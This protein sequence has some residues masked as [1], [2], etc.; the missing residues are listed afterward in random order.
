VYYNPYGQGSYG[1]YYNPYG[2]GPY[3][4]YGQG[5]AASYGT[6]RNM[7]PN[8]SGM[9]GRRDY[10]YSDYTNI[11]FSHGNSVGYGIGPPVRVYGRASYY[12][13][14]YNAVYVPFGYRGY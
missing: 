3:G 7:F 9:F 5:Y 11:P 13:P 12:Q 6:N 10:G 14:S 1:G 8:Q 4:G 2:Q